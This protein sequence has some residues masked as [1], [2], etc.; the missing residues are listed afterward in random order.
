MNEALI[1][2]SGRREFKNSSVLIMLQRYLRMIKQASTEAA[3]DWPRTE[4]T[5][6]LSLFLAAA[7]TKSKIYLVVLSWWSK[8]TYDSESSQ[9]KVK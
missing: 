8:S 6:T 9:K 3:L 4:W 7:S 1:S 2:N 5:K